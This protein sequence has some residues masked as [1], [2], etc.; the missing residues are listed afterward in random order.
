[1]WQNSGDDDSN[2]TNFIKA[3]FPF[4]ALPFG[5]NRFSGKYS[6]LENCPDTWNRCVWR[7][8]GVKHTATPPAAA[9][10]A[11]FT[12]QRQAMELLPHVMLLC[13]NAVRCK[14]VRLIAIWQQRHVTVLKCFVDAIPSR[15]LVLAVT[16]VLVMGQPAEQWQRRQVRTTALGLKRCS[17]GVLYR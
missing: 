13:E 2:W 12:L 7:P 14:E 3:K 11:C 9:Y 6:V 5:F 10:T 1:M 8:T 17:S 15:V 4:K 16:P